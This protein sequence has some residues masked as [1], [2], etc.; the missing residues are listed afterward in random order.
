[1][2]VRDWEARRRRT[3]SHLGES[4]TEAH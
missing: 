1:L 3:F 2:F 4:S